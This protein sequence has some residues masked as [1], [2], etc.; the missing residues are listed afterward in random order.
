M[1]ATPSD[2]HSRPDLDR[3][4]FGRNWTSFLAEVDGPAI[5]AAQQALCD[6][7]QVDSLAGRTFLDV[8]C[9]SGLSSLAARRLGARVHSF[10]FDADSV[11]ATRNLKDRF[12][13]D[14]SDWRIEQG[15]AL[16]SAYLEGLGTWDVVYSWGVL[17][18]TGAMWN[19]INLVSDRVAPGGLL[20]LAIYNDQGL[21]S[22]IWH[23]IK[24][25]YV[26]I[27]ALRPLLITG[28]APA[29]WGPSLV[30]AVLNLQFGQ[31]WAGYKR[32]RGMS[33][34]HDLLDWVG[35]Y[36]FEVA[37]VESL[38]RYCS[39]RGFALEKVIRTSRLGCNQFSFRKRVVPGPS[40]AAAATR[41][42]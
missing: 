24:R 33:R 12:A 6:L 21:Q 36:P 31:W 38:D 34:W 8:G 2:T 13:P 30:K 16:D 19:A 28:S 7:L 40:H 18:H 27:P 20:V 35:G 9:G 10:D 3:F 22:R 23:V 4:A 29:L 15:S 1:T 39:D 42:T 32:E 11:S 41:D 14:D 37:S 5:V 17:H 25:A 26:K